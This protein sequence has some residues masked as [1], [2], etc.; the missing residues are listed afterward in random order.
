MQLEVSTRSK[1]AQEL[2]AQL[3]RRVNEVIP[4]FAR[5][6]AGQ[7]NWSTKELDLISCFYVSG[8]AV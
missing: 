4:F 5:F 1:E 6:D 8:A 2:E 3:I 7:K